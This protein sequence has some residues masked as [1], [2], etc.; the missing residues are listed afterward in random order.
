MFLMYVDESGDKG[1]IGS[2]TRYF[3]LTGLVVHEL[4]WHDTLAAF[5]SFRQRMRATFGL[6]LREEI[7]CGSMLTRPGPLV[8]IRRNDRL[9]IIRHFLD[10]LVALG[11]V[12]LINVR[13]DKQGKPAGYDPFAKGWEALI[14]RFENTI[15]HRN[16]VGPANPDDKGL[17]FCDD[18]DGPTLR[19]LYRRMRAHN[20]VPN[21]FGPGYR[22]VPL[23]R[24]VEDPSTRNSEHSYFIQAAD[25][26]AFALYQWYSPSAY[27]K[28]KG[29]RK[30]FERL[31]PALCKV[32]S[33][34]HQFGVVE[35]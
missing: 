26:A 9:T 8:R 7:H 15:N 22:Q 11:H 28:K 19:R 20:P 2:P 32:A 1:L 3:V 29:A 17:I 4:R 33:P 30:Y 6:K 21:Q 13:V 18:T 5:I 31:L 24:I 16:F 35:L 34:R 23:V 10:E 25:A 12:T 27:V 14:Q